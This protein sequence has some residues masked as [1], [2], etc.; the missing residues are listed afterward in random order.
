MDRP[1]IKRIGLTRPQKRRLEDLILEN[2]EKI[3]NSKW[4]ISSFAE[5]AEGN[6][7]R[8]VSPANVRGAAK[9]V[10]VEFIRAIRQPTKISTE[11]L[12]LFVH[13]LAL[14]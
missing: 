10:E 4:S 3:A 11:N 9:A 2:K 12:K 14:K 1:K 6:L 7:K 13:I 8:P 5:Y